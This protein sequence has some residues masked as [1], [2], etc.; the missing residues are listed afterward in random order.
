[1]ISSWGNISTIKNTEEKNILWRDENDFFQKQPVLAY[2]NGRSYGDVCL[3]NNGVII[4]THQLNRFI[5]FDS[6]TGI[7]VCESGCLLSDILSFAI[8]KGWTLPVV[9]GT[10]YVTVG[11]AIANDVHGKNHHMRGTF[12]CHVNRFALLRSTG[13]LWECAPHQNAELFRATVGGI[14]LT[15]IILWAEIQLMPIK[16]D[17][18][19]VTTEPFYGIEK[20]IALSKDAEKTHEY[21]VAWLDCQSDRKNFARGL[22]SKANY[23]QEKL[24]TKNDARKKLSVPINLP[25]MVLNRWTIRAFN[26]LYFYAGARN[27][28]EKLVRANSFFFPLDAIH[29]WNRIYG[30]RGFYQYQCVVPMQNGDTVITNLLNTIV[31]SRQGS[32]LSVLKILGDKPS[33]GILSFPMP[34]ITLALDFPNKGSETLALLNKLDDIVMNENGRVYLAKDTRLSKKQFAHYYGKAWENFSAYHDPGFSS[35]LIRRVM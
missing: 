12:G 30:S 24:I 35:S 5:Y 3:N 17:Y 23:H 6:Q 4:K 29:H 20:F 7:L 31:K 19:T 34:G 18:L 32:F 16:S 11:G 28:S 9:P 33:P 22:F 25:S 13:E 14:G 10:Q 27:Q 1:M 8:F 21:T 26:Q 15:G 2:G